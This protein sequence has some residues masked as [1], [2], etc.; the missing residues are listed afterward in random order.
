M[1]EVSPLIASVLAKGGSPQLILL[2][3]V[4]PKDGLRNSLRRLDRDAYFWH[5][6]QDGKKPS[7]TLDKKQVGAWVWEVISGPSDC[8][9][10]DHKEALRYLQ[11]SKRRLDQESKV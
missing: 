9:L 11:Y 10:P 3:N 4:V 8:V 1:P 2:V 6:N 5:W 7:W